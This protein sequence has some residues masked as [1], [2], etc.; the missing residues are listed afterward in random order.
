MRKF[1]K[2][3]LWIVGGVIFLFVAAAIAIPLFFNP[4][5]LRGMIAAK[6]KESTGRVF[7]IPGDIKLHVFPWLAL[8]LV[9]TRLAHASGFG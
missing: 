3:L 1:V 5:D 4:T 9:S 2:I 8:S 6:V 7:D